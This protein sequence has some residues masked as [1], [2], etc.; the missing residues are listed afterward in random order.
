MIG[1][2]LIYFIGKMFYELAH[3]H[4]KS[5]WGFAILGVISYY[6]GIVIG[7]MVIGVFMAMGYFAFMADVNDMILG[8]F[9]IPAGVLTCFITYKALKNYWEKTPVRTNDALD[10]DLIQ[11]RQQP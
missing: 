1:L 10:N 6:A 8:L 9:T 2:F 7:G 4:D 5:R 3:E 11:Q